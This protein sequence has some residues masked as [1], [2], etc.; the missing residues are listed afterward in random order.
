MAL[1]L[2]FVVCHINK[3]QLNL[4]LKITENKSSWGLNVYIYCSNTDGLL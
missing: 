3:F 4:N 2:F 1:A